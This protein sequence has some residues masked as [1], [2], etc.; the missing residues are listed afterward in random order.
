MLA[1]GGRAHGQ[2]CR[3]Q[4]GLAGAGARTPPA[5]PSVSTHGAALLRTG[6]ARPSDITAARWVPSAAT[7]VPRKQR[8]GTPAATPRTQRATAQVAAA[9]HGQCTQLAS[10][11][12][13][14]NAPAP[15]IPLPPAPSPGGRPRAAAPAADGHARHGWRP[16]PVRHPR[17]KEAPRVTAGTGLPAWA[18]QWPP[19]STKTSA[20]P[21]FS[22]RG[23]ALWGAYAHAAE[24]RRC[25][26][27][28]KLHA[29]ASAAAAAPAPP[30]GA[31]R[32]AGRAHPE[33][34]VA[35]WPRGPC[36][37]AQAVRSTCSGTTAGASARAPERSCSGWRA[38][39]AGDPALAVRGGVKDASRPAEARGRPNGRSLA[40][41]GYRWHDAPSD[42]AGGP[43]LSR[44]LRIPHQWPG[45]IR[46]PRPPPSCPKSL[47]GWVPPSSMGTSA[48][49]FLGVTSARAVSQAG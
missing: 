6:R 9:C 23:A 34:R 19:G 22:P 26:R 18:A 29:L 24:P 35:R 27:A 43:R 15:P 39:H 48:P 16:R 33:R 46:P 12:G 25:W 42:A 49:N 17:R 2:V 32:G 47:R 41:C 8:R 38:T 40:P 3:K 11:A 4:F 44:R 45:A 5:P 14:L 36:Q 21:R 31:K 13:G 30:K 20:P 7:V 28:R 10:T 37:V 1:G